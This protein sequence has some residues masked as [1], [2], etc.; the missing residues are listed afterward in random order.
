M[1]I[2]I[3]SNHPKLKSLQSSLPQNESNT[4]Q[5]QYDS[6]YW[7]KAY[8]PKNIKFKGKK[9]IPKKNILRIP[10]VKKSFFNLLE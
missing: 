5:S 4:G 9:V 3:L 1:V 7:K 6:N 8:D 10:Q 2:S